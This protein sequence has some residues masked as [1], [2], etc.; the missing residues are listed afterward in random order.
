MLHSSK[1]LI[2]RDLEIFKSFS[3]NQIEQLSNQVLYEKC[4]KGN[5]LFQVGDAMT[6]V[7]VIHKGAVKVGMNTSND[8]V[9]IKEIAYK[10]ELVGENILPGHPERRLF[11]HAVKDTEVFKIPTSYFKTMLERNPNLCQELTQILIK[12]MSSL[13]TRMSNF[14][15]KKAQSR[16]VDF[17]KELALTNGMKIGF[18]EILVNHGLS[19]KE[20]ANI[21]DTSRQTVA[22]VL[23]DL[24]RQNI[25]HFS[26]RKP[27]KILIRNMV[28]LA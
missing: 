11:A 2:L 6:Y 5:Y 22:R 28:K 23:G 13:E 7:Y 1:F 12:K 26:A 15:F 25:I 3:D 19:H 4:S 16:I 14:V 18:D 20:I 8:K 10:D 9:L 17:L 24:K 27:H 21:T